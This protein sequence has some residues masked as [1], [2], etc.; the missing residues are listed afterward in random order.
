MCFCPVPKH[1]ISDIRCP[2]TFL[3][4]GLSTK[5]SSCARVLLL[6]TLAASIGCDISIPGIDSN[7]DNLAPWTKIPESGGLRYL[8]K[9]RL[10]GMEPRFLAKAQFSGS[11][12]IDQFIDYFQLKKVDSIK[13]NWPSTF[14]SG[15]FVFSPGNELYSASVSYNTETITVNLWVD[16]TNNILIVERTWM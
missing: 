9:Y 13:S 14:D 3:D 10:T 12:D 4:F 7:Q 2:Q 1:A 5:L 8:E 15:G 16:R 11:G 6:V